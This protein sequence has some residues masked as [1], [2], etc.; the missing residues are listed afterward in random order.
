MPV[1]PPPSAN[2]PKPKVEAPKEVV[3]TSALDP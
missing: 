1:I 2:I 3:V